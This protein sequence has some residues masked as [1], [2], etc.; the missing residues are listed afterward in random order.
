MSISRPFVESLFQHLETRGEDPV[1]WWEGREFGASNILAR[2]EDWRQRLRKLGV[3][4]GNAVGYRGEYSP[5]VCALILALMREGAILV[6]FTR[7]VDSEMTQLMDLAGVEVLIDIA[8]D[9]SYSICHRG[10]QPTHELLEQLREKGHAGLI[11]FSSGSTGKPKG[12]VQDCE[13]ILKKFSVKRPGYRTLQFLLLDHFGGF[14]TLMSILS[15]TGVVIVAQDRMPKAIAKLIGDAKVELL[16]VTPTFLNL[17]IAAGCHRSADMTSV[18]LITYG[19]EVM[20]EATLMRAR[21]AFPNARLQQTYGLSETGVLRSVSR[22][23]DSIWVKV[24]GQGF[25][26]RVVNCEL[27]VRSEFAMLGYLNAE[28]PF[29]AEG[30]INTHDVVEQDGEWLRILGR[31]S[32]IINVGGQKVFPAEV[33]TVLMSAPRVTDAAVYGNKHPMMGS[34]VIAD[35]ILESPEDPTVLRQRLRAYCRGKLAAHKVP[36]KFN[37]IERTQASARFKK[38]RGGGQQ[39]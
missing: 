19:T 5:E 23:S 36:V 22:D 4:E 8:P 20:P 33:E 14:N 15:A 39:G 16:P 1:L 24:G 12:I 30:W 35:V 28:S 26:V 27:H 21:E 38:L 9:D 32:D 13:R 34:V 7:A 3:A 11:I 17:F 31:A 29:D 18:R 37:I 6:P 25:E 2:S 10:A